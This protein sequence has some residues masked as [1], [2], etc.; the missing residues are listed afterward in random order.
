MGDGPFPAEIA[1][2]TSGGFKR[3]KHLIQRY[4]DDGFVVYAPHF[5]KRHDV[6]PILQL[7]FDCHQAR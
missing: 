1:L 2:H 5:L 7:H 6:D 4:V 3:L